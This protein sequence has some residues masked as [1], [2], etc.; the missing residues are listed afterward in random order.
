MDGNEGD[1]NNL[2]LWHN[3]NDLIQNVTSQCNNTVVV[4]HTVGPI[5]VDSFYENPNVTAIIWAG[6]PG[7]ESGNSIADILYGRVV[8]SGKTP[9]TWGATRESYG[10]DVLYEPNNGAL[11]PQDNFEEGIFIDYRAFDRNNNT[12][13]YEF[14]YGLSYTT[15][16]Y[17]DI[18]IEAHDARPYTPTTGETPAAPTLGSISN[19]TSDYLFPDTIDR[20]YAYIYPYLN[21]TSL[22]TSSGDP[23]YGLNY[24]FPPAGYDSSSQPR[25]PAGGAPGG[26]PALY[27]ILYTV[28]ATVTNT[29][30]VN[31]AEVA[32]LY[33]SLGGPEDAKVVLRGFEK[34]F[35]PVGESRVFR[36][37]VTRRDMS[38]W[39]VE[40]Q[41]WVV[42][43]YPKTAFVGASSRRL[44]LSAPLQG[45]ARGYGS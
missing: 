20:V 36:A 7:Q 39:S 12:P 3:G 45:G 21:T 38:N 15:F 25:L 26:N 5:L 22:R 2:T 37:E 44:G 41:D 11:A 29:G 24:T 31:G 40:M 4:M 43:E 10:T 33:I 19:N 1:R 34:L 14:G 27:D 35:I 17:S 9:F 23:S 18:N 32:Q 28:T 16:E 30:T 8:P 13:I 6:I 42:S